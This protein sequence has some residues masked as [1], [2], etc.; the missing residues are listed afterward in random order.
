VYAA[1]DTLGHLLA[2]H[3]TPATEQ[4]RVQVGELAQAVQ[5]VAGQGVE[6]AYVDRGYAGEEP[7]EAAK[8]SG[9]RL[10]VVRHLGAKKGLVLLPHWWWSAASCRRRASDT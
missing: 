1:V 8:E 9:I 3:V 5:E 7:S 4:D 6:L 10:E 2:L